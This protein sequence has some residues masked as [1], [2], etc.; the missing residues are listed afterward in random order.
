MFGQVGVQ[1]GNFRDFDVRQVLAI[2]FLKLINRVATL[3]DHFFDHAQNG[4]I[5]QLNSLVNLNL[6]D[7]R[8]D[9]THH[10]E[11]VFFTSL[12]GGFHVVCYLVFE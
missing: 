5:I 10:F 12:H 2:A 7:C 6:F 1:D 4:R 3:L 11:P 8:K 9:K